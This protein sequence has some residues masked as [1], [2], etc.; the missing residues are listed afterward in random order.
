MLFCLPFFVDKEKMTDASK[1]QS[2]N[3]KFKEILEPWEKINIFLVMR[4]DEA[5]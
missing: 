2:Q 1:F 3:D 5:I 4:A